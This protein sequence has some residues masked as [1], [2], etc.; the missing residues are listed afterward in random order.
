MTDLYRYAAFIS[1]SSKDA[2]FA[3]RLHRALERYGI[4]SSLGKFDLIGGGKRNRIYPVFRDREELAAGHLG[5]AIEANLRASAALI[6]VCSPNAAASPWVQKEIEYFANLGRGEKIFAIVADNAPLK[7]EDGADATL[8][9]FPPAFRGDALAGDKLEPLAA[10]ARRGKD[11]FRNAWLKI[12]AGMIGV[13]PGQIIDRDRRHRAVRSIQMAGVTLVVLSAA[14]LGGG[15]MLSARLKARSDTLAELARVAADAED[16]DGAARYS[17]LGLAG[18]DLPLIGFDAVRADLELRRAAAATPLEV[19]LAEQGDIRRAAFSSNQKFILTRDDHCK[20]GVWDVQ[21]RR[22][23]R[24]LQAPNCATRTGAFVSA[25]GARIGLVGNDGII[26]VVDSS[27]GSEVGRVHASVA[28]KW[29]LFTPDGA[30]I[31]AG[32]DDGVVHVYDVAHG[33]EIA[34]LGSAANPA[35]RISTFSADGAT[36][37]TTGKGA[38]P[39]CIWSR[40][41]WRTIAILPH[42]AVRVVFSDDGTRAA[43]VSSS[44]GE[45]VVVWDVVHDRRLTALQTGRRDGI[46]VNSIVLSAN[47][48]MVATIGRGDNPPTIWDAAT[49]QRIAELRGHTDFI[50]HIAFSPDNRHLATA[51]SD[52]TA[53]IWDLAGNTLAILHHHRPDA[54]LADVSFSADGLRVVTTAFDGAVRLWRWDQSDQAQPETARDLAQIVHSLGPNFTG[55]AAISPNLRYAAGPGPNGGVSLLRLSS[56]LQPLGEPTL[57]ASSSYSAHSVAFSPRSDRVASGGEEDGTV[58]LWDIATQRELR[59]FGSGTGTLW[60]ITFSGN[61][62]YIA[63]ADGLGHIWDVATGRE[64]HRLEGHTDSIYDVDFSP[65]STRLATASADGTARVWDVATG[66]TLLVL[67]PHPVGYAPGAGHVLEHVNF[68]GDGRRLVTISQ[69]GV[70]RIWDAATGLEIFTQ[71]AKDVIPRAVFSANGQ[72]IRQLGLSQTIWTWRFPRALSAP[73]SQLIQTLCSNQLSGASARFTE[74]ELERAP[75]IDEV[76]EVDACHL[77]QGLAWLVHVAFM[78]AAPARN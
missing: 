9:C 29:R 26:S 77:P 36:F 68:S 33:S 56:S 69:D 71:R 34:T 62:R 6:V 59:H 20:V 13:S 43:W 47:G 46:H 61:G 78:S 53:R 73:R 75:T 14:L 15:A 35:G 7:D 25:N 42:A 64:L 8:A 22:F 18:A 32:A 67:R 38:S 41:A 24:W 3:R 21:L 37:A 45:S 30:Q 31:L 55:G 48:S 23:R 12:V 49:G 63:G 40:A 50:N 19:V 27:S 76:S 11:G 2:R 58:R 39:A 17:L 54:G 51:S 74:V 5:D 52:S 1:Y 28:D 57:I 16:Y 4:P 65:D 72:E 66:R 70:M 10:D 44:G 60:S